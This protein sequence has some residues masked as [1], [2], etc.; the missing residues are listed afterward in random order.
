MCVSCLSVVIAVDSFGTFL[1]FLFFCFFFV[2]VF[3][4]S[5]FVGMLGRGFVLLAVM[6]TEAQTDHREQ[7]T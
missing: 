3:C 7:R 6:L 2:F 5:F 4:F 1:F